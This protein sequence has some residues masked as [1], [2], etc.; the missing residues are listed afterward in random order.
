MKR[1]NAIVLGMAC[2][3]GAISGT[4]R[5]EYGMAG[6]G[7]GS[8]AFGEKTGKIQ[9][10]AATTNNLVSPQTFAISSGTS[11]CV[12]DTKTA[13]AMFI[14]VNEQAL[15]KDASR[16]MGESLA[17]LSSILKCE[18]SAQFGEV[19]QRNYGEIFSGNKNPEQISESIQG[20][21]RS[22]MAGNCKAVI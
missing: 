13:S 5:A 4:A 3:L 9:I 14:V 2:V 10:L 12:E 16:G 1:L 19:V 7:L 15:R 20:V 17:G 21:V 6:C 22:E 8:L 18:D 11:G